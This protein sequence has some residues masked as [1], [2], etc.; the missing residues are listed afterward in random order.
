M[1]KAAVSREPSKLERA[2]MEQKAKQQRDAADKPPSYK[3]LTVS[4][5]HYEQHWCAVFHRVRGTL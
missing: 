2:I 3:K 1:N 4:E 5:K